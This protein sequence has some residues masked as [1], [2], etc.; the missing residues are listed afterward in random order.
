MKR[1]KL[2][3]V[4]SAIALLFCK[5]AAIGQNTTPCT[6]SD[7]ITNLTSFTDSLSQNLDWPDDLT[8]TV[9]S[10]PELTP[11]P[12]SLGV[13]PTGEIYV[14]VDMQGSLG[15][16]M[17]RGKIVRLKDCN[18]D[19]V[20]DSHTIFAEV[21]N[22]RGIL[23]I[24]DQVFVL[25]TTFS[26]EDSLATGQ[27]LAVLED[28]DGNGVAD[29]P[30]KLLI[31][32]IGN[33]N[34]IQSRGTDHA[35]NGI[36]M[37]IDG[38]IYIAVGDFGFHEAVDREGTKLTM[39]GGGVVRVRP[40]GTGMEVYTH[41]FRN[42][43]D[44]AIDPYMNI[45]TRGNTND[46]KNWNVRFAHHV[47]TGEYGYT[48]L[49]MN[50]TEEIIPA[51]ADMGGGS[52]AGAFYMDDDRWP[53]QYN[54]VPL[55]ADWGRNYLFMHHV[56][57]DNGSF[58]QKEETFIEL[59]QITDLDIDASGALYLSAWDDAGFRGDSTRGF[60]VRAVPEGFESSAF[61]KL[62]D[63]SIEQLGEYL[64]SESAKARQYAQ[65][66][67][68]QRPN[69]EAADAAWQ[70]AED[71]M[72]PTDI[73]VAGIFSYAQIAGKDGI[74]NLAE[75]TKDDQIREFALRA[76]T[77]QKEY[78][79]EVP[80]E[81]FL[82]TLDDPSDRVKIAAIVG[83]GRMNRFET[84]ADLLK[85]PVPTSFK[86]PEP[87]TEGPHA[88]PNPA[89][90]PAHVAVKALVEIGATQEILNAVEND[91]NE[92]AMWAL[93]YIHEQQVPQRLIS[94]YQN[95]E[96]Q[97]FRNRIL[98]NLARIYHKE[99]PYDGSW[100]WST[101]PDNHGPYYRAIEW[102]GTPVIRDFLLEQWEESSEDQNKLFARL[103]SK[104]RLGISEF[105]G[106]VTGEEPVEEEQEVDFEALAGQKGQV[107]EASIED[108]MLALESLS[109]DV[110]EELGQ[111]LYVQQGCMVCHSIDPSE[112]PK[113][114]FLGQ[115]GAI[116]TRDQIAE[117]ILSPNASISQGFTTVQIQTEEGRSYIGFVTEESA[118]E[119]VI[120]DI[121]GQAT[122]L[123]KS[124]ISSREELEISMMPSGLV[125]SLS[126]EE[127][128]ALVNY[129]S[130]QVE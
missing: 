64:Q 11:S 123:A 90:I 113:G 19:G 21:D 74:N 95:S 6:S 112:T 85:I 7:A 77:D 122:T 17:G 61:P 23:P 43:Y 79:S 37:G 105:G 10:G 115:I 15:K 117:A 68:L 62:Q 104:Y 40:D 80:V 56:N 29:G 66:E 70:I 9:F 73:R 130:S 107:G 86:A 75:L 116:M 45:F 53:E 24:G 4:L 30:P 20:A 41:G 3:T 47:Q 54:H 8:I 50:F 97:E 42:I 81:P 36:W 83:L 121:T 101:R 26:E 76:L 38:W 34:Y 60:I 126:Y 55:M 71:K 52:G 63:A 39:L 103:N 78:I 102:E 94:I 67:L 120:R 44:V 98:H 32:G 119:L 92:L 82:S 129:L 91:Q 33:P 28:I 16:E 127:F 118:E 72:L 125:N 124:D 31:E 128:T 84:T 35:T 59:P 96:D 49:F 87:G 13:A 106:T 65:Y 109:D 27:D 108:V 51:L 99:A 5:N 58:V 2:V 12:A 22:P 93:R 48:T 88:S 1:L 18:S 89:I 110:N 57:P 69:E 14:G 46:G 25:Y 111:K 114:P 100:W